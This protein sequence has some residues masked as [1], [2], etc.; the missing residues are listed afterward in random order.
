MDTGHTQTRQIAGWL[1]QLRGGDLRARD[2]LIEWACSRLRRLAQKLL[3]TYPQVAR[4]E[5]TDDILQGAM[6]RL[7]RALESKVPES[8]QQ[9]VAW[10]ALQIRRELMDLARRY[11]SSRRPRVYPLGGPPAEPSQGVSDEALRPNPLPA[12]NTAGPATLAEWAD[13]HSL[14]KCLP[15]EEQEV[16]DMYYYGGL[17]QSEVAEVLNVSVRT[18]KR[19]WQSARLRLHDA[20]HGQW[21]GQ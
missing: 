8:V 3:Q 20:M 1:E 4:W 21:P 5:Q 14:V 12:D 17:S 11:G 19:L 13:F 18:V 2:Q 15:P 9:F 16:F 6:L 10:A 7:Q